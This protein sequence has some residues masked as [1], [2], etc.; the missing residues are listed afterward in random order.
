MVRI[1][2]TQSVQTARSIR[3]RIDAFSVDAGLYWRAIRVWSTSDF[4]TSRLC[5]SC[6]SVSAD[7]YGSVQL[8]S[9]FCVLST[10][11]QWY[12]AWILT[13]VVY[14]SFVVGTIW[15]LQAF[16]SRLW[17]CKR[18]PP[19]YFGPKLED[20]QK[21]RSFRELDAFNCFWSYLLTSR[22]E[23]TLHFR[24]SN[25][26]RWTSADG[27]MIDDLAESIH[28]AS[29]SARIS[30]FLTVASFISRTILIDD[31]FW[32]GTACDAIQYSA[33]A[34][35]TAG[36][37]TARICWFFLLDTQFERISYEW[38]WTATNWTVIDYKTFGVES[39][40]TN[41]WVDTFQVHTSLVS[42]TVG[43]DGAFWSAIS[44]R[45]IA[46]ESR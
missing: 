5:V 1:W 9:T 38:W 41:A 2:F 13:T 45:C 39:A 12:W 6:V 43:T 30:A 16:Y 37:R 23:T 29:V 3:A 11:A 27:P 20:I 24:R 25:I 22:F 15:I 21:Y 10:H 34:V 46:K 28:S 7:A 42:W 18:K 4:E 31:T 17:Y 36:R 32:I 26:L 19:V 35:W 8:W 14:T 40:Y 44:A 33:L